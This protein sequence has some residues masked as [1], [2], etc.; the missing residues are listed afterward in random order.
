MAPSETGGELDISTPS[1]ARVCAYLR[2]EP[3]WFPAD[4]ALAAE[5]TALAPQGTDVA[6]L[7][8]T[9]ARFTA[10]AATWAASKGIAQFIDAG[11]GCPLDLEVIRE[12]QPGARVAYARGD[13]CAV[14]RLRAAHRGREGVAV[15]RADAGDPEAVLGDR[16]VRDLI[17][18]GEPVCVLLGGSLSAM[19]AGRARQA[20]AG[21]ARAAAA[22][23]CVAVSCTSYADRELGDR[24]AKVLSAAGTWVNHSE[25]DVRTFFAHS[26]LEV[27]GGVHDAR[28]WPFAPGIE[29]P[30]RVLA[31][32]GVKA[33]R[34]FGGF[35]P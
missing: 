17:D 7:A 33:E 35:L 15:A 19:S 5:L 21:Y 25:G 2:G 1:R 11:A 34:P 10:F 16:A 3:G 12:M 29:R 32:I 6:E 4:R 20:A 18:P 30:A 28:T 26:R 9:G 8:R 22:G 31:G 13:A 14:L 24:V 23:S 27:E